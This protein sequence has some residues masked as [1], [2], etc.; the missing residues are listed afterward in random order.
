MRSQR[1]EKSAAHQALQLLTV[2]CYYWLGS[3]ATCTR[4]AHSLSSAQLEAVMPSH[5]M[6][7]RVSA[8]RCHGACTPQ[9]ADWHGPFGL[10]PAWSWP[11]AFRRLAA[12]LQPRL[13]DSTSNFDPNCQPSDDTLEGSLSSVAAPIFAT[14]SSVFS[15]FRY[16]LEWHTYAPLETENFSQISW[17][18]FAVV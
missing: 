9:G 8:Q 17:S 12:S 13:K 10:L 2:K 11:K 14:E 5:S 1:T 3:R 4:G 6:P 15:I 16:I 18:V 7:S